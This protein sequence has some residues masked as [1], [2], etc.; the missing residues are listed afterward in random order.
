MTE[1]QTGALSGT[2]R[3]VDH[4]FKVDLKHGLSIGRM[5]FVRSIRSI[6]DN[7]RQLGGIVISGLFFVGLTLFALPVTYGFGVSLRTQSQPGLVATVTRQMTVVVAGLLLLFALRTAERIHRIDHESIILT[8]VTP[9][10]TLIGLLIAELGRLFA[11]LGAPLVVVYLA[12]V[13]GVQSLLTALVIPVV[14]LPVIVSTAVFGYIL[15]L[16]L[17]YIGRELPLPTRVKTILW[18]VLFVVFFIASQ[19]AP[20]LVL[21]GVISLPLDPIRAV[22]SASPL[23]AYGELLFVGTPTQP[24]ISPVAGVV[25]VGFIASIPVGFSAAARVARRLW[26]ADSQGSGGSS[27]P[28]STSGP[29]GFGRSRTPPPLRWAQSGRIAWLLLVCVSRSPC[30]LVHL[31]FPL[32][33]AGSTIAPL[34]QTFDVAS[35]TSQVLQYGPFI[36]PIIGA[37]FGGA[38]LCLNPL[39]D[40]DEM[41]P[42]LVLTAVEAR[43]LVTARLLTALVIGFPFAVVLPILL[44]AVGPISLTE[45]LFVV[46]FGLLLTLTSGGIGLGVGT[47]I[48]R[49]EASKT[50]GIEAVTPSIPATFA[51]AFT[52]GI[53]GL[54]GIFIVP[55][56]LASGLFGFAVYAIILLTAGTGGFLYAVRRFNAYHL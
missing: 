32:I 30:R 53:S 34:F 18:P 56:S 37:L 43:Q 41:L 17:N 5:E 6:R 48:P 4:S 14:V 54:I 9:R 13:L 22:L 25:A 27:T 11:Y 31:T 45:G 20:Q 29:E 12:F 40:D 50:M 15:G 10:A 16:G 8:T 3:T 39:G 7:R 24:S 52:V 51:H 21:E 19:A 47:L 55:D 33:I 49:Y 42:A 28:D 38:T 35:A 23:T 2:S 44:S 26:F 1:S 36:L 46:V